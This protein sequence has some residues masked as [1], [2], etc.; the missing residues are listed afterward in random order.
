[1]D[2]IIHDDHVLPGLTPSGGEPVAYQRA[3]SPVQLSQKRAVLADKSIDV[4][5]M[6]IQG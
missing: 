1:V 5:L 6:D 2:P 4:A 3:T